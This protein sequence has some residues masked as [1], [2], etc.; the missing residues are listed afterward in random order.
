MLLHG[1]DLYGHLDGIMLSPP[2]TIFTN[3][4]ETTN[5]KYKDWFRQDKLIHNALMASI[6]ATIASIIAFSQNSKAA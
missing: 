6:D 1:H 2:N 4:T 5:P 3:K